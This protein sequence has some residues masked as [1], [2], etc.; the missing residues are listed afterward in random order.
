MYKSTYTGEFTNRIREIEL[1]YRSWIPVNPKGLVLLIHGAG[2]HSGGYSHIGTEC[3]NQQIGFMA[4]D[5]RGFGKSG[6][7]RGHIYRFEEYLEDLDHLITQLQTRYRGLPIFLCGHSLGGLIA[8]RFA[9][10]FSGKATGVILSS[11]ALGFR[12]PIPIRQ[13]LKLVSLL[14]PSLKL[15][16]VKWNESLRKRKWLQ[17]RLPAWTSELLEDPFATI[18]YT[19]RWFAELLQNGTKALSESNKFHFPTLCFYDRL[20]PVVNSDLIEQFIQRI[21]SEDKTCTVYSEGNHI[22]LRDGKVLQQMFQWLS[23]KLN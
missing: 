12:I 11:P 8:I 17:S 10:Q 22:L 20:D 4:P 1:Y 14:I 6:G 16:L 18:Q 19:P 23:A 13:C 15:E 21:I 2:E 5:L 9:Q 3:V 7:Q